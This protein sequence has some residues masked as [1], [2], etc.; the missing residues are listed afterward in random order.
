MLILIFTVLYW[1]LR[2]AKQIIKVFVVFSAERIVRDIR[3]R[4]GCHRSESKH[5]LPFLSLP[6]L[7]YLPWCWLS[8]NTHTHTDLIKY[9]STL[10]CSCLFFC[11]VHNCQL[12]IQ[13]SRALLMM[14]LLWPC[15][16]EKWEARKGRTI[17]EFF[18]KVYLSC[19][20]SNCAFILN[21][22]F[23]FSHFLLSVSLFLLQT[24][25]CTLPQDLGE[26]L[27]LHLA[28][29]S[30]ELLHNQI[31]IAMIHPLAMT[32]SCKFHWWCLAA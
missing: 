14:M 4:R 16:A 25:V 28:W 8:G 10:R 20:G 21:N 30:T 32:A 27:F 24:S 26:E 19:E 12:L 17:Q 13:Y 5:S 22:I 1:W 3:S 7:F 23:F 29:G 6:F 31:N 9:G 2:K 15:K 18:K 11:R